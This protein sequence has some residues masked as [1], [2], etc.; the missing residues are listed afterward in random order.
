MT[1][2]HGLAIVTDGYLS[3]SIQLDFADTQSLF[4]RLQRV[5]AT[6]ESIDERLDSLF[7][8]SIGGG[9]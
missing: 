4:A 5:N 2:E 8:L 1:K 6:L 9:A 7:A 3:P